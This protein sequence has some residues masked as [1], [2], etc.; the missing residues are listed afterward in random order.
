MDGVLGM[1]MLL[2][3]FYLYFGELSV[4]KIFYEVWKR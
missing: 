4:W 3:L 1:L 2:L